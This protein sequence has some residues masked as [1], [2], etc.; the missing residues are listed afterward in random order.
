MLL[1]RV[2]M[3]VTGKTR[4]DEE[5]QCLISLWSDDHIWQHLDSKLLNS[6]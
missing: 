3:V 5:V 2:K 4:S 1:V 6:P